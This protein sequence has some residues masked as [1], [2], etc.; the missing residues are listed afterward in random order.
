MNYFIFIKGF[1]FLKRRN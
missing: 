1:G